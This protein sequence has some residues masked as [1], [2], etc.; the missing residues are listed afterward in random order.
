MEKKKYDIDTS[1]FVVYA[2]HDKEGENGEFAL[3]WV[4]NKRMCIG[5]HLIS[6]NRKTDGEI[7][8]ILSKELDDWYGMPERRRVTLLNWWVC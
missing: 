7:A 4:A 5:S 3:K 8:E 2:V 1:F 6:D